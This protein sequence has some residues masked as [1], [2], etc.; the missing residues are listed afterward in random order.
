MSLNA[1]VVAPRDLAI[2]DALSRWGLGLGCCAL[3][4][5]ELAA[6]HLQECMTPAE[7]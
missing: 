7:M 4:E 1:L 5:M 6:I 2:L 3:A